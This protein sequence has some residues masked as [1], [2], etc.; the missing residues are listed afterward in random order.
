VQICD[1][2]LVRRRI[3]RVLRVLKFDFYKPLRPA[4][5]A[6][7]FARLPPRKRNA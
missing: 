1:A 6:A 7:L 3:G 5:M 4:S 2:G